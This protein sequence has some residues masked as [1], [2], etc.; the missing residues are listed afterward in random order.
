[1]STQTG[2]LLQGI[3]YGHFAYERRENKYVENEYKMSTTKTNA[4]TATA[5]QQLSTIIITW[6]SLSSFFKA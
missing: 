5:R 1:M 4:I 2:Y 3:K 6:K